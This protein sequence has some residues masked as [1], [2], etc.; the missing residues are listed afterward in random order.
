MRLAG[1]KNREVALDGQTPRNGCYFCKFL[2]DN[3]AAVDDVDAFGQGRW[4]GAHV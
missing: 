4:V 1:T 3:F 2:L